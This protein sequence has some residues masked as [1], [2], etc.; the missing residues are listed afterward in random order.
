MEK[1]KKRHLIRFIIWTAWFFLG[2]IPVLFG[3]L[4]TALVSPTIGAGLVFI[5]WISLLLSPIFAIY[6]LIKWINA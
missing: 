3:S 1:Q 2:V 5:G 4:I 6:H